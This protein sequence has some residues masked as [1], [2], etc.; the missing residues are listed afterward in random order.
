ML[1]VNDIN[2]WK[3]GRWQEKDFSGVVMRGMIVID[4]YSFINKEVFVIVKFNKI[5]GDD[6]IGWDNFIIKNIM[7]IGFNGYQFNFYVVFIEVNLL[8][9]V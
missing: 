7:E 3:K 9:M 2:W 5:C 6:G 4:V 1:V 8:G